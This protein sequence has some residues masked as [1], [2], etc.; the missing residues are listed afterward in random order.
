MSQRKIRCVRGKKK[1]KFYNMDGV[2]IIQVGLDNLFFPKWTERV[3]RAP[4]RNRL[5]ALR[6][7]THSSCV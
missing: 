5:L 7:S 1:S 4:S 2:E 6:H 3:F